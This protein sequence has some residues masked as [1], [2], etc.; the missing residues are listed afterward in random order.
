MADATDRVALLKTRL[1][2]AMFR[3][4]LWNN[5]T[6]EW[7]KEAKRWTPGTKQWTRAMDRVDEGEERAAEEWRKVMELIEALKTATA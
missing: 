2:N 3:H 1:E 4:K 5:G 6:K 7:R